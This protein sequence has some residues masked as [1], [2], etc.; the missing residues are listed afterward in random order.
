M[1]YSLYELGHLSVAP[2]RIAALMQSSMLR[3][4]LN[5]VAD[6]EIARTAA[7]ASDLFETV[8]RRYRK[9]DWN[10]PHTLVNGADVAVTV[11]S[12]WSAPWC[13]MLHFQRDA[14]ALKAARGERTDPT[15]LLVAP[16]SGHYATLLRSTVEAFLPE[17][18]VYVTDWADARMVPVLAGRFDLHDYI[19]YVMAM[20]RVL[21]PETHVVAVCQPGPLVLAAVSLMSAEGDPCAPATMTFM[22]SPIDA[23]K[24][25]TAPNKLAETRDIEWFQKNMI[26][27]VPMLYPGAFRRVYPGF[28]QLASFMGMNLSRHVD[29]H[30]AY[31]Q[32]LVKGDGDSTDK[33]REFYDEY[34]A[35]MDLTE[36]FYI[37]T[38]EEVFQKYS[39]AN[40]TMLHRGVRVDPGAITKTALLTVEGEND[41]ISGIGQTQAAHEL[42]VNIPEAMQR[43]YIQPGVGHYGVFSGRRFKQEIYPRMRD[44]MRKFQ[45]EDA[46][47]D[48][49]GKLKLVAD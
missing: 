24:S 11:K 13:E 45:S 22:G 39:L 41:D 8:T 7:A 5:P 25:P 28:L 10:L 49:R 42:C 23:R 29:A 48:R 37:Q 18:E 3:S 26:H 27:T 44:F 9:P 46:R 32:N 2:L 20:L 38:L 6:T 14:D 15:V 34:L 16:M 43:D 36:E 1:L 30:Y 31:F 4:P 35:V 12:A 21:G 47:A 19:D 17:H 40:G 33:H